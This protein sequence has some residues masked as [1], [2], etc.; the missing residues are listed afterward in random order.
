VANRAATVR[1]IDQSTRF[2]LAIQ[3]ENRYHS[4]IVNRDCVGLRDM[5]TPSILDD[6]LGIAISWL[7]IIQCMAEPVLK[8]TIPR[9]AITWCPSD[10][11][12]IIL[13]AWVTFFGLA[14]IASDRL[15][16]CNLNIRLLMVPGILLVLAATFGVLVGM[17]EPVEM[18]LTIVGNAIVIWAHYLN[19]KLIRAH[20]ALTCIADEHKIQA[21]SERYCV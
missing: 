4:G 20:N 12:H 11:T 13:A 7:C 14:V 21:Q 15:R 10:Q 17:P 2:P 16:H 8:Q 5:R 19:R 18:V 9:A 6:N 3:N 1:A